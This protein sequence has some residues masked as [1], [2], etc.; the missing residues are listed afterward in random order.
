MLTPILALV[1]WS[2]VI[3]L[4]MTFT[5]IPAMK[6]AHIKPQE[7]KHTEDL[8]N[9]PSEVRQISDNYNH[10]LEQPTIFYAL[11]IFG[12]LAGT[13]TALDMQLAWAYVAIRVL[14]SLVQCTYNLVMHR[15]MLFEI[16]TLVLVVMAVRSILA[17][18]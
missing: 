9:L 2:L 7:A 3:W 18:I 4:W 14:H 13:V 15:F 16:S 17:I 1:S 5:R 10:L 11:C 6:K 8:H 12:H